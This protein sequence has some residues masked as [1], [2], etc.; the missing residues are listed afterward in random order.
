MFT[1]LVRTKQWQDSLG[2]LLLNM[3]LILI[4]HISVKV[5]LQETKGKKHK[6]WMDTVN[7]GIKQYRTREQ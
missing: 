1:F 7:G 5:C 2:S 4:D 6:T 3:N